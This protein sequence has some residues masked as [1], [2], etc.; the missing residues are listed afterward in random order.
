MCDLWLDH[1][2]H[3][4]RG[5]V[6]PAF[7]CEDCIAAQALETVMLHVIDGGR[8]AWH[9]YAIYDHV[10]GEKLWEH[11]GYIAEG[12]EYCWL[13]REIEKRRVG[14]VLRWG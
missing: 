1:H 7:V 3:V 14:R 4:N 6:A 9:V 5:T 2:L 11:Q 10:T 13:D 12:R 8:G